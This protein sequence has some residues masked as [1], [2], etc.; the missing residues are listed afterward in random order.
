[1]YTYTFFGI[2]A[3]LRFEVRER[4][5]PCRDY[6]MDG[7]DIENRTSK[8]RII[9]ADPKGCDEPYETPSEFTRHR[10]RPVLRRTYI[11]LL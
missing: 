4:Y 3:L 1:M 7:Y 10:H 8:G 6:V 11:F 2:H 5:L 9:T